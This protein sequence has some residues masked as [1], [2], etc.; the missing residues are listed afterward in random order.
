MAS[1]DFPLA[2]WETFAPSWDEGMGDEGNEYF[3]FLELPILVKLIGKLEGCNAIDLATGN[4]L[5]ARW[6][7]QKAASVIATDGAATMIDRAKA[8]TDIS[9]YGNKISFHRLDVTSQS[10]WENFMAIDNSLMNDGF[11]V[12]TM[13]MALMDIQDLGPLARSLKI[14]LKPNGCFV[15]TLL[16]PLFFTSGAARQIVVHEDPETGQRIVDRSIVVSKY[17]NVAPARQ[18]VLKGETE[19]PYLFHRPLNQLFAPFFQAGLVLDALE[20]T[21]FDEGFR[22]PLREHASRNFTEFPKI[23]GFRMRH[24]SDI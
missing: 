1:S 21:N 23:L 22:D 10:S 9:L 20:E 8:R 3:R 11:D 24:M 14:L 4:G 19:S 15:A 7:A 16:H 5:V 12:I 2:S 13:N 6:L 18:L 17:L